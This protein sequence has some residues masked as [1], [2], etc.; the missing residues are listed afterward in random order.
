MRLNTVRA[1][2]WIILRDS[3]A[4]RLPPWQQIAAT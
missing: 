1:A 3:G 4:G 2:A